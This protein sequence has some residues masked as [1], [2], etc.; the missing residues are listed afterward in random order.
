MEYIYRDSAK[1]E[2]KSVSMDDD[3]DSDVVDD[4]DTKLE[5]MIVVPV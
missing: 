2:V 1:K 4:D 5:S 3:G